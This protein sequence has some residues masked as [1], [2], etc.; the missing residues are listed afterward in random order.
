M[1]CRDAI[2]GCNTDDGA[3]LALRRRAEKML[4]KLD[5][6]IL[7]RISLLPLLPQKSGNPEQAWE[8][9]GA[10]AAT[11]PD[12]AYLAVHVKLLDMLYT[13]D[14]ESTER[15]GNLANI[16]IK[17]QSELHKE[18]KNMESL[19]RTYIR[20]VKKT[21]FLEAVI[22][23]NRIDRQN[24]LD[25][26]SG[27]KK[28]LRMERNKT[29]SQ[30]TSIEEFEES[31]RLLIESLR[32]D[33]QRLEEQARNA[34]NTADIMAASLCSIQTECNKLRYLKEQKE[35]EIEAANMRAEMAQKALIHDDHHLKEFE[36]TLAK[37]GDAEAQ[38]TALTIEKAEDER[39]FFRE[40][41]MRIDAEIRANKHSSES[42]D[43]KVH[44]DY[45]RVKTEKLKEEVNL[46]RQN[47]AQLRCALAD[48]NTAKTNAQNADALDR[49]LKEEMNLMLRRALK[50]FAQATDDANQKTAHHQ[51]EIVRLKNAD[52]GK[53]LQVDFSLKGIRRTPSPAPCIS[54]E[55][56]INTSV[57]PIEA[58][59]PHGSDRTAREWALRQ[60]II[61]ETGPI[62]KSETKWD[63]RAR[64]S[65][66]PSKDHLDNL[67]CARPRVRMPK[68]GKVVDSSGAP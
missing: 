40:R 57:L 22:N 34:R 6:D 68:M 55:H 5:D 25:E 10:V 37:L 33:K 29:L 52:E 17:L 19:Q 11:T 61:D 56:L 8:P 12:L 67:P 65:Q 66:L 64:P 46:L 9:G 54:Q 30:V 14:F 38:V 28:E 51:E 32:A 21:D 59:A 48:C 44:A 26:V 2:L 23:D 18:R 63:F 50:Q 4:M 47:L 27:L 7:T 42:E 36:Q 1:A 43:A 3:I 31:A 62:V 16:N 49:V 35:S 60:I 41:Q 58:E 53:P 45:E 39:N 13:V 24:H 15:A 20:E